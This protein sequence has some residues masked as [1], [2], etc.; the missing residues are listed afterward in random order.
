[1]EQEHF[2]RKLQYIKACNVI[3][4]SHISQWETWKIEES[5]KGKLWFTHRHSMVYSTT[6]QNTYLL[7]AKYMIYVT[8]YERPPTFPYSVEH[9]STKIR[10]DIFEYI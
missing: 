10:N 9:I 4:C 3:K 7:P 2:T 8:L 5:M 1:M 6:L